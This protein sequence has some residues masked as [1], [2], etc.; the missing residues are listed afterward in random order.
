MSINNSKIS[1]IPVRGTTD[2]V[3]VVRQ[4]QQKYLAANKGLYFHRPGVGV[5]LSAPEVHLVGAEKTWCG[6]VDC[7]T[8][9]VDV[10]QCAELCP[11]W[12]AVQWR[13][14]SEGPC[15]PRIS[16]QPTALHYCAWSLV[17]RVQ[18]WGHLRRPLCRWLYYHCWIAQGMCQEALDSERSN[19]RDRIKQMQERKKSWSVVQAWTSC[20]V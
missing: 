2:T 13:V 20:K 3:F 5:W 18:L 4:L 14:W 16:I 7:A 15:S 12:W 6:G 1:F 17:T 9:A 19:R 10:C 11:C 8:G